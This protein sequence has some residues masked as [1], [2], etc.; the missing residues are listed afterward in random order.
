MSDLINEPKKLAQISII[1]LLILGCLLVLHPFLAAVLFAGVLCVTLWP[2]YLRLKKL[3]RCGDTLSALVMTILLILVIILP[4]IL[5]LST[6]GDVIHQIISGLMPRLQDTIIL[7]PPAWVQQIPWFGAQIAAY[8]Q[9]LTD[10]REALMTLL[11][12]MQEPLRQT[13]LAIIKLVSNGILQL[14]LVIFISFF[15]FRD[16][17]QLA[18]QLRQAARRLGGDLGEEMLALSRGTVY[19]VMIGIVGTALAQAVVAFIGFVVADVPGALLLGMGTFFLSM[20]PVGPPLIWGG[21][22]F[23]LYSQGETGWAIGMVIYGVAVIS[24]VD[25]FAKPILI[26]R[27]ASLPI[28]LIALGVFGG[29]L[30]FGFIGIFLG[31][32]LLALAHTLFLRWIR[33]PE[34]ST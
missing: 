10:N 26:S 14:L 24:S 7:T 6:L 31:P 12:P 9:Q 22:A 21:A 18:D 29:I 3:L 30:A 1:T 25:N 19:G 13:A 15:L 23:W 8:L 4:T 27:S 32:T 16:G 20:I 34:R 28:L 5:L 17:A 11:Q 2:L 33:Q